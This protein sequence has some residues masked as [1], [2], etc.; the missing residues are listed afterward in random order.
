MY[1]VLKNNVELILPDLLPNTN[2]NLPNLDPNLQNLLLLALE[3]NFQNLP[4][5]EPNLQNLPTLELNFQHLPDLEPNFQNLPIPNLSPLSPLLNGD[6][7]N[8]NQQH[9]INMIDATNQI[10]NELI[11]PK[12]SFQVIILIYF[13]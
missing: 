4:D 2:Q 5:L 11:S 6:T 8:N 1:K 3:S 13:P 9:D 12:S 7:T 10:K